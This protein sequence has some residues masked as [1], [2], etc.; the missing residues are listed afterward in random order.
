MRPLF[1][2]LLFYY[3]QFHLIGRDI[4]PCHQEPDKPDQHFIRDKQSQTDQSDIEHRLQCLS[5]GTNTRRHIAIIKLLVFTCLCL[6]TTEPETY[7][8]IEKSDHHRDHTNHCQYRLPD[9]R[10]HSA[11]IKHFAKHESKRQTENDCTDHDRIYR[12]YLPDRDS[13]Y[14][15]G[16]VQ[17]IF[18]SIRVHQRQIQKKQNQCCHISID[19]KSLHTEMPTHKVHDQA[20]QKGWPR[21]FIHLLPFIFPCAFYRCREQITR[22][23]EIKP[24]SLHRYR[25]QKHR[26]PQR[27]MPDKQPQIMLCLLPQNIRIHKHC[28]RDWKQ[29]V[30]YILFQKHNFKKGKAQTAAKPFI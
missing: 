24:L 9:Q 26:Q 13:R 30:M 5:D 18:H 12:Q 29:K 19:P 2:F 28:T 4:T 3:N 27:H 8:V 21:K 15:A 17:I 23:Q 11:E 7:I 16:R 22:N 14:M 6:S 25:Q 20:Q 10:D 1:L